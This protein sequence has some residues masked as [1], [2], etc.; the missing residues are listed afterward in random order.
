MFKLSVIAKWL[1]RKTP[2][3]KPNGGV[4]II[5][6]KPRQQRLWYCWFIVLLHCLIMYFC[7]LLPLR[8]KFSYFFGA[9]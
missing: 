6:R 1:H 3:E 2:L 8:D 4:G 9:I 5:S 7:C